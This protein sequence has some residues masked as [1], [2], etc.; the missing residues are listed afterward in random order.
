M[1][2]VEK[3]EELLRSSEGLQARLRAATEAYEGDKADER[4]LFEAV[5]AP[6]AAA[7]G[8]PFTYDEA[9]EVALNDSD[10]EAVAGGGDGMY[11]EADG[12][13]LVIGFGIG[14]DACSSKRAGA[15]GCLS[16]GIGVLAW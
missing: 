14:G 16:I 3:F 6:I 15:G 10:L 12:T 13:C 5:V 4:A 1:S 2:N 8:L 11:G 7:A 9:R